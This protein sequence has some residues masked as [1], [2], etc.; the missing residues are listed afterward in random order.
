MPQVLLQNSQNAYGCREVYQVRGWH[1]LTDT[2][3]YHTQS[4]QTLWVVG[5]FE[6]LLVYNPNTTEENRDPN[7][8]LSK[9]NLQNFV[10][11]DSKNNNS[12][13]SIIEKK[14]QSDQKVKLLEGIN[15]INDQLKDLVV[16]ITSDNR[17]VKSSKNLVELIEH[18]KKKKYY[19]PP[20]LQGINSDHNRTGSFNKEIINI[21][22]KIP[23]WIIDPQR[24]LFINYKSQWCYLKWSKKFKLN[25][26]N[27]LDNIKQD[28]ILKFKEDT[29]KIVSN[30][31]NF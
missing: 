16:D 20:R 6:D 27:L 31:D 3:P 15:E 10:K 18:D 5:S 19:T 11:R 2:H 26:V 8:L 30:V 13:N 23:L 22:E 12:S 7:D 17:I 9:Q 14:I 29:Y 1:V 4:N 28:R 25:I 24:N 21:D